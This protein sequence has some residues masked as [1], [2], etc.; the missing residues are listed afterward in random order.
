MKWEQYRDKILA[1][2]NNEEYYLSVLEKVDVHGSHEIKASCPF[3]QLH[4][5]NKDNNPSLT[6]NL[7]KGTYY[8]QTCKSKG[9]VHTFHM[10]TNNMTK[11]EAWF[12]LGDAL[13]IERPVDGESRPLIDPSIISA[14]HMNLMN[15]DGVIRRVLK[16]RRGLTDET[17]ARF[18]LGW[19]DER[20]TIPVYDEMNSIVNIRLYKWN[21]D[22]DNY[23]VLNY[24]DDK[25]NSFGE[26]RIY[27]LDSLLDD[28]IEE[29]VWSEG[30]LDRLTAEQNGF[31]AACPTS[32]AGSWSPQ[33]A[34]YFRHKKVVYL[35]QDNDE[36][37]RIATEKLARI[38]SKILEVRI[39]QWPENFPNKG[40]ITDY[41]TK[42]HGDAKGFRELL[43]N[44]KRYG[45]DEDVEAPDEELE[46]VHLS[47]A[48]SAE[49]HNKKIKIPVMVSG[50][51]QN[52]F[53]VPKKIKLS[54]SGSD[55]ESKR[56][57]NCS[58]CTAGGFLEVN[59]SPTDRDLLKLFGCNDKAKEGAVKG[60]QNINMSC[61]DV[62]YEEAENYKVEEVRLI[63][64]AEG[65]FGFSTDNKY[66]VTPGYY[67]TEN[68]TIESNKRYLLTAYTYSDPSAQRNVH[69][70]SNAVPEHDAAK[71]F[72]ITPEVIEQLKI[73]K[74]K[75]GQSI[76][77]KFAEIHN[78]LEYN[79]TRIWERKEV[80][81]AV[82]LV[83]HTVMS[84]NFQKQLVRKGWAEALIIG[85][86]GQAKTTL[87][88]NLMQ[89]YR[90]GELLSG[91][92]SSRTGL[93]Y[94]MQQIANGWMLIWGAYPLNDGGL[95]TI[96]ELS[97]LDEDTLAKM[98][99]VR[100]SGIAK[101]NG[102]VTAETSART[103]AIFISNPRNGKPLKTEPFGIQSIL[104]LFG[105]T[106][107]VRRLDFA[108]TVA[109]GEVDSSLLNKFDDDE[110]VIPNVYT[111]DL[112]NKRV[113][114]AW[115]RTP[116]QVE[117]ETD[118]IKE[119]L[120]KA[121][122]MSSMYVSDI[123]I[124]EPADQRLK[125]AR[126]SISCA[127]CMFSTSTGSNVVVKK[128][129][130]DFVVDYLQ[131]QYNKRSF[132]YDEFSSQILEQSDN[133]DEALNKLRDKFMAL[134]IVD[135][136]DVIDTLGRLPYWTTMT[137][138]DYTGLCQED[139]ACVIK[140]ILKYSLMERYKNQYRRMPLG[141]DFIRMMKERPVTKEDREEAIRNISNEEEY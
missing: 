1:T 126:L 60:S 81:Y 86:S 128:E 90:V 130:V 30:E 132:G 95:L 68:E 134:P 67:I 28:D 36:A 35:C 73:F 127:A 100:S 27:G 3:T 43:N 114:W 11:A 96:D 29:L 62:I 17:L 38:M 113:L 136:N 63:P 112:C 84:F 139:L 92:S 48:D 78:D 39:I 103:R 141:T 15:T 72:E 20:L 133:S 118:A 56:C 33:W 49:Y 105:K 21:S 106:E 87:V 2:I 25:G 14:Y 10:L 7:L 85:D 8:C 55:P 135:H 76:A 138:R 69:V 53:S 23:K 107:D 12:D 89:H 6:V 116:D 71:D 59:Y 64:K 104:K 140:F 54:C 124:V 58:L 16:E 22:D 52:S 47:K 79:V 9:N 129:H 24:K 37:G 99:D 88:A 94:N 109:S 61:T 77:D 46:V 31:P 111:S 74:P 108:V 137:L 19:D 125:L 42:Y 51:S 123:P 66:K 120:E 102:V 97:G 34:P 44:A 40:D 57:M 115:S 119:I 65:N 5:G 13:G 32:G 45:V 41:F 98:S 70:F 121:S 18:Q 50:K 93:V 131:S 83:Y 110:E 75:E 26:L 117:F 80:A 91:E 101:A 4:M 82:D 122:Y